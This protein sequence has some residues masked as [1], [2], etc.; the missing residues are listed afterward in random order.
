MDALQGMVSLPGGLVCAAQLPPTV[1]AGEAAS[2]VAAEEAALECRPVPSQ[3]HRLSDIKGQGAECSICFAPL[4]SEE[5]CV[6]IRH[7][8]SKKRTCRHYFHTGCA[9]LLARTTPA[10][11]LCPLCRGVFERLEP[12]P[13]VRLDSAAWFNVVDAD[14]G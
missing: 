10:P 4:P 7:V 5:V 6:L 12:L 3:L 14:D 1:A 9:Q 8:Y 11:H 13:D 2:A